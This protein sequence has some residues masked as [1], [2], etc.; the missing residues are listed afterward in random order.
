LPREGTRSVTVASSKRRQVAALCVFRHGALDSFL[1]SAHFKYL[2]SRMAISQKS[3]D[4]ALSHSAAP[5]K[6]YRRRKSFS[7]NR[8]RAIRVPR[9][10]T[11]P[12]HQGHKLSVSSKSAQR[13]L[14]E[15]EFNR[16]V[17]ARLFSVT[18]GGGV[19]RARQ[20]ARSPFLRSRLYRHTVSRNARKQ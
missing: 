3:S 11:C 14:I 6:K 2:H 17:V 7:K 19:G 4:K 15:L 18:L 10:R 1:K 9:G 16:T 13:S 5:D 8:G 12:R 20:A